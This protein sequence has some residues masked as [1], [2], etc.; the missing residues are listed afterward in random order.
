MS[1]PNIVHAY[2]TAERIREKFP[3]DDWFHLTGFIHDL[4]KLMAFYGEPQVLRNRVYVICV[5]TLYN[6]CHLWSL[7]LS[8]FLSF[9]L[10]HTL[11]L[12]PLKYVFLTSFG[13]YQ[14]FTQSVSIYLCLLLVLSLSLSLSCCLL[15]SLRL[16]L[17]LSLS[18]SPVSFSLALY[19]SHTHTFPFLS[20]MYLS[21]PLTKLL[22]HNCSSIFTGITLINVLK[23]QTIIICCSFFQWC[24]VGDTFV[25]GCAPSNEI[26]FGVDNFKDN[27]DMHDSRY[28]YDF[29]PNFWWMR[30]ETFHMYSILHL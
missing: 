15:L 5:S 19:L 22:I 20:S 23:Y 14:P 17:S 28:K 21:L 27:K 10:S 11:S 8:F 18:I 1:V 24:V 26:V 25:T 6:S 9:F 3:N 7:S 16:I 4:G 30:S 12:T 2:Q 13:F 29:L